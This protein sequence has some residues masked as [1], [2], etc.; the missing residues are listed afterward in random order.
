MAKQ[1]INIGAAPNDGTGD[2]LRV[3]FNKT[4]G[5][6]D[7]LYARQVA[8]T[9]S[10]AGGG[11]LNADRTLSLV[12]DVASPGANQVYGTNASGVRGW[13]ADPAGG[14]GSPA[15]SSGQFQYNN[16]SAFGGAPLWREDANTIW[17]RNGT[18][19]QVAYVSR[20]YTDAS[21]YERIAIRAAPATGW[22]QIAAE[23]AGTGSANLSVALSPRGTGAL[24]AHVPDSAVAGGNARGTNAVDWQTV[25]TQA[26]GVASGLESVIGGGRDN[27][28][29]GQ[30][31][32]VAGGFV[33]LAS[34]LRSFVGGGNSNTASGTNAAVAG[35]V[36][37]SASA[38]DSWIPGGFQASTRSIRYSYAWS[39]GGRAALGDCQRFGLP[40]GGT[41]NNATPTVI[42]SDRGAASTTNILILPNNSA[43]SG[44]VQVVARDTSGNTAKWTIDVLAKRG[45]N[46]ASTTIVDSNTLRTFAEAALSTA[47]V[48]VIADTTNGGAAVQ[49]TGVAATTIDWWAEFFGGQVVR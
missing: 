39:A 48:S 43:W 18:T 33:N 10:L 30:Q 36:Q 37:N 41:T 49:V 15:G 24:S 32:V 17:Q 25:R 19:A 42:T 26:I 9:H 13:K 7:E 1:T 3:A 21:N 14:G 5:N 11:D 23:S 22:T 28:A 16:A 31:S 35:G 2:T 34:G 6:F 29:S 46:A 45:A 38:N 40:V 4:N 8:T 27:I 12:G 47:A 20:T 44:L